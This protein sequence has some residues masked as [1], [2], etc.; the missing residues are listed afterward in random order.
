V[1]GVAGLFYSRDWEEFGYNG[2]NLM[3]Y[4]RKAGYTTYSFLTGYHRDWFGLSALYRSSSDVYFESPKD[5]S[6][7]PDDDQV[8]LQKI[9]DTKIAPRSFVY[10]HLLSTHTIGQ[11]DP[12]L[13][14]YFPDKIGFGT[15]QKTALINNYDNGIL[16]ADHS[17]KKIFE[18]LRRDSLIQST[19]VYIL[20]D[21][22]ELFGEDGRWSHGGS[23]HQKLVT[24]PLL[25]Y[26]T[27]KEWYS[28]L[29]TATLKDVA[30]TII[31][32]LSYPV[33]GCWEGRSLHEPVQDFDM[34]INSVVPCAFPYGLISRRDQTLTLQIMDE[35]KQ[36]KQTVEKA[37][38][39]WKVMND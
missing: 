20:A 3:G 25:I 7:R 15:N 4:L 18:K 29:E 22:G 9:N 6:V 16:Q 36:V 19:T 38:T 24:V 5:I 33:P 35:H 13:K 32:R 28:N 30:P 31:D 26:D 12:A 23:V 17:I 10:V 1:G 2:L 14:R 37:G 21:H 8:T 27:Q 39:T 34:K 11:K